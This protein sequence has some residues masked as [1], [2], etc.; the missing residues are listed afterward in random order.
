M[1]DTPVHAIEGTHGIAREE[2][3]GEGDCTTHMVAP[4]RVSGATAD[5]AMRHAIDAG[6]AIADFAEGLPHVQWV[7]TPTEGTYALLSNVATAL[8]ALEPADREHVFRASAVTDQLRDQLNAATIPDD[9]MAA[10]T[11]E[12]IKQIALQQVSKKGIDWPRMATLARVLAGLSAKIVSALDPEQEVPWVVD[13][14]DGL[15]IVPGQGAYRHPDTERLL[16]AR[17]ATRHEL[18]QKLRRPR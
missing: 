3:D 5:D 8:D 9:L 15:V 6:Q 1:T 18:E 11:E 16:H 7:T 10:S 12:L 13:S 14:P 2:Y 17:R 4:L